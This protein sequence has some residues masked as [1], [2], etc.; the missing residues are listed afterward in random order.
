MEGVEGAERDRR[1][2]GDNKQGQ[3]NENVAPVVTEDALN[4]AT[5]TEDSTVVLSCY[6]GFK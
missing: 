2:D 1:R 3:F 6:D 5:L 4:T